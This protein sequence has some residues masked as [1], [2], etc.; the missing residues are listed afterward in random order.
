MPCDIAPL[1]RRLANDIVVA[2][3]QYSELVRCCLYN[4]V[5]RKN[6]TE[7]AQNL[8]LFGVSTVPIRLPS[9]TMTLGTG[10]LQAGPAYCEHRPH[11][12]LD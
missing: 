6:R 1:A 11:G 2:T 12:E 9:P 5:Q 10:K 3:Q 4:R 8:A 7:N